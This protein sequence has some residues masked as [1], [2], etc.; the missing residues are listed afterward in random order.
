MKFIVQP[1]GETMQV[2]ALTAVMDRPEVPTNG[3]AVQ[4]QS[5]LTVASGRTGQRARRQQE[6]ACPVPAKLEP[7]HAPNDEHRSPGHAVGRALEVVRR[8]PRAD[9]VG[10]PHELPAEVDDVPRRV[11]AGTQLGEAE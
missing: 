11:I 5:G 4:R 7:L 1:D 3:G 8:P 9:V 2:P 6:T 10:P